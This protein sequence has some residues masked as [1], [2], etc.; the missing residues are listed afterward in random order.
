MAVEVL[1]LATVAARGDTVQVPPAVHLVQHHTSVLLVQIRIQIYV[2]EVITA[3]VVKPFT[4]PVMV[5]HTAHKDPAVPQLVLRAI[6]A[7]IHLHLSQSVRVARIQTIN[8]PTVLHVLPAHI[9]TV[10]RPAVL[11]VIPA[12]IQTVE[13]PAVLNVIPAHIRAVERLAVLNVIPAHIRAVELPRVLYVHQVITARIQDNLTPIT[14]LVVITAHKEVQVFLNV[15]QVTIPRPVLVNQLLA[16]LV[17]TVP[18]GP[19]LHALVAQRT[20]I[21]TI[22]LPL[23]ANPVQKGKLLG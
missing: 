17:H 14:V 20:L 10:E 11:N 1:F 6:T 15:V 8:H 16:H 18:L 13:R 5:V 9:Q 22:T 12:H 19:R 23:P 2:P 4:T 3:L 21:K 7:H